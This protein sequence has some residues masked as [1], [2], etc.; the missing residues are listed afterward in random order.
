MRNTG[1]VADR[2]SRTLYAFEFIV[3][4]LIPIVALTGWALLYGFGSLFM[5]VSMSAMSAVAVFDGSGVDGEV[6]R[7]LA[8]FGA[9]VILA[10]MG[11]IALVKFLHLSTVFIRYG[12]AELQNHRQVFWRC[13]AWAALP[14]IATNAIFPRMAS[15]A[16]IFLFLVSGS[17]L[18]VPLFHLWVELH[19]RGRGS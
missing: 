3:F 18:C 9:I 14:L 11:A 15:D 19:Y 2:F 12:R 17:T 16:R 13:L 10:G 6:L 5:L 8:L 1:S 7:A 4:A